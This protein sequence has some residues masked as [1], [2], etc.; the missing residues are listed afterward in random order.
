MIGAFQ[1]E[2]RSINYIAK[3]LGRVS[4]TSS[5]EIRRGKATQLRSDLTTYKTYFPE[6]GQTVYGKNRQNSVR[7]YRLAETEEFIIYAKNTK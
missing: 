6:T 5:C 2:G 1:K 3:V 4:G 7:K